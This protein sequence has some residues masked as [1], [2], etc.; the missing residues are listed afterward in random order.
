MCALYFFHR[1]LGSIVAT[2]ELRCNGDDENFI[3]P[4]CQDGFFVEKGR[5]AAGA[6]GLRGGRHGGVKGVEVQIV[7]VHVGV[8]SR[9]DGKGNEGKVHGLR[10]FGSE[11]GGCVCDDFYF[12]HWSTSSIYRARLSASA[13]SWSWSLPSIMTRTRGSVPE[14]RMTTRPSSLNL[15]SSSRIFSWMPS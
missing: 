6:R 14:G 13:W 10:F 1:C 15:L 9:I 7:V 3:G 11:V 5:G 8:F 12:V 4:G 2:G